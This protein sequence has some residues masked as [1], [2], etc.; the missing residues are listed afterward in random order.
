MARDRALQARE[1]A[2]SR[3][4][5]R[6]SKGGGEQADP[7]PPTSTI[8]PPSG[9]PAPSASPELVDHSPIAAARRRSSAKLAR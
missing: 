9:G 4:R 3:Q 2:D 7:A 8:T 5:E 6:T 1:P